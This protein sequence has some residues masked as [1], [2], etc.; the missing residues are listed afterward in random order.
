MKTVVL[1]C[2]QADP[3]GNYICLSETCCFID[4]YSL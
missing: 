2:K 4:I 1:M 3:S